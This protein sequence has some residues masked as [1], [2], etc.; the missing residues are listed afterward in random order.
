MVPVLVMPP[1]PDIVPLVQSLDPA[2]EMPAL[3]VNEPPLRERPP[4]S[5]DVSPTVKVPLGILSFSL[6]VIRSTVTLLG[7]VIVG[8]PL[9]TGMTASSRGPGKSL[10][11]QPPSWWCR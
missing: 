4:F 5:C 6:V 11:N 9:R 10:A 8:L 7:E 3:A 2:I 1:A